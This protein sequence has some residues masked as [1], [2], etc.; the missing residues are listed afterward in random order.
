MSKK[1]TAATTTSLISQNSTP[2]NPEVSIL[3]QPVD[4]TYIYHSHTEIDS[5][6]FPADGPLPENTSCR[7]FLSKG[8]AGHRQLSP[9]TVRTLATTVPV[10]STVGEDGSTNDRVK[11]Q[12]PKGSTYNIRRVNLIPI[13]QQENVV[14]V[15]PETVE[16]RR[17]CIVHTVAQDH[18]IEIGSD[19]GKTIGQIVARK[20]L[21]ID[22]S[23]TSVDIARRDYPDLEFIKADMLLESKQGWQDLISTDKSRFNSI[24]DLVVGVDINGN[25]E[26]EAVKECL[27]RVLD[28]WSPRLVVVKSRSLFQALNNTAPL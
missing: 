3:P 25:R 24:S 5:T 14:I 2:L 19:L 10:S 12:Y 7:F 17:L 16:Y 1:I 23:N 28:W 26:L 4:K 9:F 27:K 8:K 13:L 21:G 22:K 11:V 20:L 6:Y 18:F 15:V